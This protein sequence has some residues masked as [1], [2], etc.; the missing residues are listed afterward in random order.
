MLADSL[1]RLS[2]SRL[3]RQ[4]VLH[5][6]EYSQVEGVLRRVG[7]ES[8]AAADVGSMIDE[9]TGAHNATDLL[10]EARREDLLRLS[11][12][13]ANTTSLEAAFQVATDGN[14]SHLLQKQ[15][16]GLLIFRLSESGLVAEYILPGLI[17]YLR[18]GGDLNGISLGDLRPFASVIGSSETEFR[19]EP[20]GL[21]VLL[22]GYLYHVVTAFTEPV[23]NQPFVRLALE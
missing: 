20:M 18:R 8:L 10:R 17:E 2:L 7:H 9:Q 6:G 14:A 23:A 3:C 5:P 21:P 19:Y 1:Y 22:P 15:A 11:F 13:L 16:L 4:L 12:Q